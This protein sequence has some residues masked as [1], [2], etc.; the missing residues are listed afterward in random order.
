MRLPCCLAIVAALLQSPASSM[1]TGEFF[2]TK[3]RPLLVDSCLKCHGGEKTSSGLC[4]DAREHLMSGG[5]RGP[6]I[7]PGDASNS[8]LLRAMRRTHADVAMP[9]KQPLPEAVV[10]DFERWI[11]EGA[12]WPE[13]VAKAAASEGRHW[14]FAPLQPVKVPEV[15]GSSS[16]HPIDRF[17]AARRQELGLHPARRADRRTL[18]RRASFDLIGLPPN[19]QRSRRFIADERPE[20]YSELVDELLASPR[21]GERWGRHWLDLARYADTAGENSDYPIPQARLY[22]DYVIDAFNADKPVTSFRRF[23]R[24]YSMQRRRDDRSSVSFADRVGSGSLCDSGSR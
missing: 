14:A 19:W 24:P 10:A 7:V 9:P 22:R 20:A 2:E 13:S 4:L 11:L 8:L 18:I 21:Y 15:D 6:A 3:I 5:D 1:T 23:I 16:A 12:H 17:V